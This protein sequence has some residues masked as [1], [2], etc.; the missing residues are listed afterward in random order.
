MTA[1]IVL[2]AR[3]AGYFSSNLKLHSPAKPFDTN[4]PP[5]IYKNIG[6]CLTVE[7]ETSFWKEMLK[8]RK[9]SKLIFDS[10]SRGQ[11]QSIHKYLIFKKCEILNICEYFENVLQKERNIISPHFT[12]F[13][14]L[15]PKWNFFTTI[16]HKDIGQDFF[17]FFNTNFSA[18][19]CFGI[20]HFLQFIDNFI[21]SICFSSCHI[22]IL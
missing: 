8:E 7:Q 18:D 9:S 11:V 20:Y 1:S 15:F 6:K 5:M 17:F 22:C 10:F 12:S 4:T 21:F 13:R 16:Y 19:H 14:Y 2:T 3:G